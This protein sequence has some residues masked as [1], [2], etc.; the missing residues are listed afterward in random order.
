MEKL[1]GCMERAY[2]PVAL[3]KPIEE[4]RKVK[5]CEVL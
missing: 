4:R 1:Y 5:E 2:R 3:N